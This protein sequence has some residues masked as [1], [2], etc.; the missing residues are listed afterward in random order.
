VYYLDFATKREQQRKKA[1]KIA[2]IIK[3]ALKL[4]TTNWV[5]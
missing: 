2:V 3:I 1:F 4:K 5:G